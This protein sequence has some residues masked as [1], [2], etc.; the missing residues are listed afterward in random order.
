MV[1]A[2]L[3][4]TITSI[5]SNSIEVSQTMLLTC[6][7]KQVRRQIALTLVALM[8]NELVRRI[9]FPRKEVT[10]ILSSIVYHL[11]PS[12]KNPTTGT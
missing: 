2:L 11:P 1:K 8:R 9:R 6:D 7:W 10:N 5:L 4:G 12:H 3:T